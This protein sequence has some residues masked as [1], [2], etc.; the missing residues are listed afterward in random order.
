MSDLITRRL[1]HLLENNSDEA[2]VFLVL[3]RVRSY[4]NEWKCKFNHG[5]YISILK[6]SLCPPAAETLFCPQP[7]NNT[8][9]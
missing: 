4:G 3:D 2:F 7:Y 8:H 9:M 6:Q 5:L 1:R